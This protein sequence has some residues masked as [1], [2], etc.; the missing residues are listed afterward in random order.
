MGC[1]T[2]LEQ[3]LAG[4]RRAGA[5]VACCATGTTGANRDAVAHSGSVRVPDAAAARAVR[6]RRSA[7]LGRAHNRQAMA[8]FSVS[9]RMVLQ[10]SYGW[11]RYA[12][13]QLH[14]RPRGG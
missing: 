11:L 9:C 4:A 2:W 6:T 1:G 13:S 12:L 3:L 10:P 8:G 14:L 7:R 5:A